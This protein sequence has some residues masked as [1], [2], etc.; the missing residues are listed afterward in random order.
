MIQSG[1]IQTNFTKFDSKDEL[2]SAE[3]TYGSSA[4]AGV[5][6]L[7]NI[8]NKK[9]SV[10]VHQTAGSALSPSN[11][12]SRLGRKLINN[13]ARNKNTKSIGSNGEN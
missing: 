8:Q 13:A 2:S 5:G 12:K 1:S 6:G 11:R 4:F 7:P 9:N 10:F 3:R